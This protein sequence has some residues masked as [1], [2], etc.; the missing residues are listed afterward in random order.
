VPDVNAMLIF[1]NRSF[2]RFSFP[3]S[4]FDGSLF[5][6]NSTI[7]AD[8]RWSVVSY[9]TYF[10]VLSQG[11]FYQ[12]INYSFYPLNN[13]RIAFEGA[14]TAQPILAGR[15]TRLSIFGP[16]CLVWY[17]GSLF[18]YNIITNTWSTWDSPSTYAAHFHQ[19]P[20]SSLPGIAPAALAITGVTDTTKGG[21]YRIEDD[22]LDAG[23]PGET[24]NCVLR[25]KSYAFDEAA[26]YKRMFYWTFEV[27]SANGGMG[28][29]YPSAIP[30]DGLTYD[31]LEGISYDVLDLGTVDNPLILI[32]SYTTDVTFP[33]AAPV[34][35]L[36]KAG[37]DSRLLRMYYEITLECDGTASTSPA[38]IYSIVPYVRIKASVSKQVS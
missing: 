19:V 25:T 38:R 3:G 17:H 13:K 11:Y 36:I 16:R 10:L 32:P 12:L 21:L 5:E 2:Y 6:Q 7:G 15:E 29:A 27:R 9:E 8:N 23:Q 37:Q 35:A 18:C 14:A 31:D 26:Q 20:Q 24:I 34:R 30:T 1:R 33:T 4:P 22:V 28:V